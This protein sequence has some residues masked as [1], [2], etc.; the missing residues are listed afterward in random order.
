M[1]T[2][3]IDGESTDIIM[4]FLKLARIMQFRKGNMLSELQFL[5]SNFGIKHGILFKTKKKDF[6]HSCLR[7]TN[8]KIVFSGPRIYPRVRIPFSG[9]H[10]LFQGVMHVS[11]LIIEYHPCPSGPYPL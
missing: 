3:E 11:E 6:C 1:V 9:P 8:F 5:T 10:K 7:S 2:T 4:L